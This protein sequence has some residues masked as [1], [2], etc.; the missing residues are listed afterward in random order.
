MAQETLYVMQASFTAGEVSPEVAN[1]IDIDK[2]QSALLNAENCYIR[3]YGSVTKRGGTLYCGMTKDPDKRC[4]LRQFGLSYLL[5][6]GEGYVRMWK[7][8]AYLG[9]ECAT[10]YTE[11]ELDKLRFAQSADV[12]FIASGAH[13]VM[14]LSRYSDT[15]WRFGEYEITNQYYDAI[16]GA[17]LERGVDEYY[18]EPGTYTWMV[19]ADGTYT[20]T[21]AGAGGGGGGYNYTGYAITDPHYNFRVTARAYGGSG[22]SGEQKTVTK[23]LKKNEQYQIVI[24]AGGGGG[25]NGLHGQ[26]TVTAT[27]GTAGGKTSAFGETAKGGG[28]GGAAVVV[29]SG[30]NGKVNAGTAGASYGDGGAGGSGGSESSGG[31]RGDGVK[32]KYAGSGQTGW[33]SIR[34]EA[35]LT[36]TPSGTTGTITLTAS[37]AFFQES[38]TG[39]YMKIQHVMPSQTVTQNGSGTSDG[40]LCGD[41]WKIITHGTWT[42][43]VKIQKSVNGEGW[44]DY[45]EYKSND[46]FNA[47]ESGTVDEYTRLRIVSTAGNTDL[48][49]LPYTHEG[50]VKITGYTSPTKVT[51]EV[52]EP[53]GSTKAVDGYMWGAWSDYYGWPSAIGFFQDRLCLAATK[54]QPYYVWMSR[55][56]DYP[57]FSVE[58]VSGTITDDSAVA[59]S[60]I[61]RKQN[62]IKHI[63][64]ASDLIVMTDGDEWTV[65]GADTVTPTKGVPKSQTSRGCTD[66]VPTVVGGRIVYVQRRGKTVRDMG[67]SFETDN[68]DGMD[69][70]LLAKHLT[71]DTEIIDATYMQDPDSILYFVLANGEIDCLSYVQDQKV[72]AWS[73]LVT[74][75][76]FESVCDVEEEDRDVVYA[77]VKRTIGGTVVRCIEKFMPVEDSDNPG[78]YIMMDCA[79]RIDTQQ[80]SSAKAPWLAGE[81]VGVLADGRYYK[82][83]PV[84]EEGNFAIPAKASY[85]IVGL[86]YRTTIELPNVEIS[87]QNGTVQGRNKKVSGASLRLLHTLGGRIG[88]GVG[89][90]D[91]IKY[92]ELSAQDVTLYSDDKEVTIPNPTVE[93]HGRVVIETEDPYP[94]NLAAIV[95]EVTINA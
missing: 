8:G 64:A 18:G 44:E 65:S 35:E 20:I 73:H 5:E 45:R 13:P 33:V 86:P 60:F 23:E 91:E 36:L 10:P 95:R 11:E 77:A 84:D 90:M 31:D 68:Y 78:D 63:V 38:M 67:Y 81:T 1:R 19:P 55:T 9:Q 41:Q 3:P 61:S 42:G 49:I 51:A 39:S 29:E 32:I 17:E 80:R 22:G 69:L 70:T 14:T 76:A 24:G 57:N 75:G 93:K 4:V 43:S 66:V 34:R 6:F 85:M 88:N 25:A 2:Y 46:D 15:D 53:L 28:G 62:T 82:D 50:V 72:Y 48:T 27:A 87:T 83:I 21:L 92:D 58:K 7:N 94:F 59:L 16:L 40:I 74:D 56:G 89:P 54:T 12:L 79:G 30:R 52:I 71:K 37:K 47:S 26:D